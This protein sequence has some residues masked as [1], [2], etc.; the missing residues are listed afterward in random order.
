MRVAA[1]RAISESIVFHTFGLSSEASDWRD[2]ALGQIAGATGGAYHA[3]EDPSQFYC[4]L[5]LSMLPANP[6]QHADASRGRA[7]AAKP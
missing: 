2:K 3:V 1:R 7:S 4:H 6:T 5:A